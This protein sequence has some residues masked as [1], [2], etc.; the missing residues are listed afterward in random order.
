[1]NTMQRGS[2]DNEVAQSSPRT[3]TVLVFL[4]AFAITVSYLSVYAVT[5]ALIAANMMSAW[6]VEA[7][8]RPHWMLNAFAGF[9]GAFA[10]IALFFRWT[11]HRQ[12]RR[13]DQMADAED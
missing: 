2:L 5:N 13:I 7:D 12:L 8:P 6:P 1:M 3:V 11:S 4:A 9:F 10:V